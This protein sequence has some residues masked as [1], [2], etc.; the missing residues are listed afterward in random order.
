MGLS[1]LRKSVITRPALDRVKIR[2]RVRVRVRVRLTGG[3]RQGVPRWAA[4]EREL[5]Q[6]EHER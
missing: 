5:H 3:A 4:I 2:V 1:H 6:G